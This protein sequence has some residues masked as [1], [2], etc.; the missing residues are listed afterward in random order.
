MM[1]KSVAFLFCLLLIIMSAV[2][3]QSQNDLDADIKKLEKFIK[4]LDQNYVDQVETKPIIEEGIK[5]MLEELDPHSVYFTKE[6]YERANEP[7]KGKY[8]GIG[9]RFLMVDDTMAIL[10]VV[11]GGA[12]QKAGMK[13]GDRI[14]SINGDTIAGRHLSSRSVVRKIKEDDRQ[15]AQVEVLRSTSSGDQPLLF[16]LS[17]SEVKLSSVPSYF[18]IDN[19]IGYIKLERFSSSSLSDFREGMDI[20]LEQKAKSLVLDLRGNGGGYLNVAE[21]IID[22]FLE[23]RKLIVYS[24]G[25]HQAKRETFASSGGRFIDGDLYV[26]IDANSASASE[27][28]AGAMQD[29]DRGLIVGRRS[30]GK[31]LV[32]RTIEFN[33]GAA[34]RLTISRYYTPTGRSIQRPYDEG[35]K[36]YQQDLRNRGASGELFSADSIHINDSLIY[37]TPKNR[38][39]YGGGG[40]IPDVFVPVDSS[41]KDDFVRNILRKGLFEGYSLRLFNTI[42]DDVKTEYS[43]V[44]EFLEAFVLSDKQLNDF[45]M[46]SDKSGISTDDETF[47]RNIPFLNERVKVCLSRFTF[48]YMAYYQALVYYDDD[49]KALQNEIDKGIYK[50]LGLK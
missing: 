32:Q 23:D 31:G 11:E 39:V 10:D 19:R 29:W 44:S 38:K 15:E 2:K 18:M 22:E 43:D 25:E 48:G 16:E 12:A 8:K 13:V 9:V 34:M 1:R 35:V 21:K 4:N 14:I 3:A 28:F 6:A 41:R 37:Y 33:D 27:I 49:V 5:R 17:K 30:Y 46:Y 20:L 36:A 7:L 40:I 26:L 42:G 50:E 47:E 45:R 24:E